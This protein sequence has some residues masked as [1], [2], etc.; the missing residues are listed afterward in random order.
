M[1]LEDKKSVKLS[2]NWKQNV[3]KIAGVAAMIFLCFKGIST[4][5]E[6]EVLKQIHRN[7]GLHSDNI[8]ILPNALFRRQ[9]WTSSPVPNYCK[10]L[11]SNPLP[12]DKAC[13]YDR[14]A[15]KCLNDSFSAVM[16]SQY[17]Q[18]YYLYTR[19]FK[20]L[21]RPGIYVDI[22]ANDPITI[23]N[24]YF[25]D[26]CL[27]W[28]GICVEANDDYYEPIHRERSC[29]LVPTCVGNEEGKDVKF[30]KLGGLGGILDSTYKSMDRFEGL[31]NTI[32]KRLKCTTMT[33][34]LHMQ[35]IKTIDYLSLDVEGHELEVL[36]GFPF[37]EVKVH[38][39]TIESSKKTLQEIDNFLSPFGY[40]RHNVQLNSETDG[41]SMRHGLLKEDSVYVHESVTFGN[42]V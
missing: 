31:N 28:G 4:Y 40:T 17:F 35:N 5:A 21:K 8:N 7:S 32:T 15:M 42:P 37:P 41:M 30:G 16:F 23:S 38:I 1:T 19:H 13:R 20:Y 24:T 6:L 27:G 39:M 33:T 25:F 2:S 29:R 36:K 9:D 26:R 22:A 18:D 12:R 14:Q 11:L 10:S 34:V 3:I